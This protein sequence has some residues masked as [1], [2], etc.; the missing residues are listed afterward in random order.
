MDGLAAIVT[1]L[2]TE[3]DGSPEAG[4]VPGREHIRTDPGLLIDGRDVR[5]A[6]RRPAPGPRQ[7]AVDAWTRTPCWLAGSL[8]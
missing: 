3:T 8:S 2:I 1:D 6:R 5:V 4:R 7:V